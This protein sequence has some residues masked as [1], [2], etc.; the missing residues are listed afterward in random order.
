[1][2]PIGIVAA[3]V[4][5][6]AL[7]AHGQDTLA[8]ARA[9]F[10]DSKG[11]NVGAATLTEIQSGQGVLISVELRGLP[12]GTHAF[13]IHQTGKCE[14]PSFK[15]AGGH[16]NPLGKHH[17]FMSA[18]GT[19]AG[20]LPNIHVGE[21]GKL[22]LEVLASGVTLAGSGQTSLFDADGST[23]VVHEGMDDYKTDPAGGAG[24][25]IACAVIEKP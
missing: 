25:R 21:D 10:I 15:S 13:H 17:G 20:D 14:A 11:G 5:L 2:R 19:H 24:P 1:M 18:K 7:N 12:A 8:T 23:L 3:G 9:Q 4:A 22:T 16:F 6:L